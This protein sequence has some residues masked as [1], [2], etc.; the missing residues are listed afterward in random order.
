[1][2]DISWVLLLQFYATAS[3]ALFFHF[4]FSLIF[5]FRFGILFFIIV[6]YKNIK[7]IFFRIY[8]IFLGY[9]YGSF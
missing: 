9:M 4:I 6:I 1:M 3:F 5:N 7:G 2:I 8:V